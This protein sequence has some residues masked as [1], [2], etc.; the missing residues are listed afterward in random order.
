MKTLTT[1]LASLTLAALISGC[2]SSG[3]QSAG[4]TA[5]S[6]DRAADRVARGATNQ[7]D[8]A[9]ATLTQLVDHPA[10]DLKPQFGKFN[11]A[12]N[13]LDSLH[14]DLGRQLVTM[15]QQGVA[16]FQK[17]DE[18]LAKIQNTSIRESS[19]ERKAEVM[20]QFEAV[21]KSAEEVRTGLAPFVADMNDIRTALRTDLTPSGLEAIRPTARG[22]TTTGASV[23]ESLTK[24]A[25]QYRQL[26]ASLSAGKPAAP[27][28]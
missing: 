3:Y 1:L 2:A 23:R 14:R 7:V 25:A 13:G 22:L 10:A 8:T 11:T 27:A 21:K 9:L 28:K 19:A 12:V 6:L 15:Q 18:A 4:N 5:A 26:S 24:L 20:R 17:W 16:H